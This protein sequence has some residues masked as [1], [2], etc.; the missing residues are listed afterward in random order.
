MSDTPIVPMQRDPNATMAGVAAED[1]DPTSDQLKIICPE[2]M[3]HTTLGSVGAGITPTT[4]S[5]QDRDGNPVTNQVTTANH[6]VATWEGASNSRYA[7][8]VR[9][10]EPV[11]IF[12]R[13][14]Q[15]KFYWR[16]TGRGRTFRTT[17]RVHVE[18]GATDPTKPGVEKDD[19]NTY[20]MYADT[21]NKKMGMKSSK[22]NGEAC[23]FSVEMDTAA[24]TLHISDDSGDPGNRI[25][26]DT[27][28]KSGIPVLQLNLSSGAVIKLEADNGFIKIPKKFEI[29]AG[30]RIVLDSPIIVLNV[31][32]VGSVLINCATF[33]LNSSKDAVLTV[34][35]ALGINAASSKIS[36]VLVANMVRF[37]KLVK[38]AFG[39][40]YQ[41]A[42]AANPEQGDVTVPS[43][44]AD[45]DMSSSGRLATGAEQ[46]QASMSAITNAFT[47]IKA[48]IDVPDVGSTLTALG[49]ASPMNSVQGDN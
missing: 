23:A 41:G 21:A 4:I 7:P 37:S 6:I 1:L 11:E 12:Q 31:A 18:V 43:N 13:A 8:L 17:D 24:G 15:D 42:T 39:S 3:P 14:N 16:S 30:E 36:G 20:S 35:N 48:K 47:E 29:Q 25:F 5:L 9:K 28:T 22:V 34:A 26:L 40:A 10:G 45:T 33:A 2:L 49:D 38:G 32:Q 27:G 46:F 44:P 19:T